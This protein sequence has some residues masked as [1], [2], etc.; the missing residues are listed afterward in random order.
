[1]L[2]SNAEALI[3]AVRFNANNLVNVITQEAATGMV[4]M[5]AWMDKEAFIKTL[6]TGLAHYWSRSRGRLWLKGETSGQTQRVLDMRLDCDGDCILLMVE[7]QGVACHTGRKR[8]F[9]FK[10]TS[11]GWQESEPVLIPPAQLYKD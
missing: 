2:L 5:Q 4:L 8:C 6:E 10:A 9:Y 1:M 7:Q 11:Q 3:E